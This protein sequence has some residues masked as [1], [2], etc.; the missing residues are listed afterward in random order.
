MGSLGRLV[1]LCLT[2]LCVIAA[3]GQF[4]K[5]TLA[6]CQ[7]RSL[8]SHSALASY[9]QA[10]GIVNILSDARTNND[11]YWLLGTEEVI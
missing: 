2:I 9:R 4:G 6:E 7:T 5:A 8:F 3:E 11:N 10:G 1:F